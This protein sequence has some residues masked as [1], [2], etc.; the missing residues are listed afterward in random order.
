[1]VT[2]PR[3]LQEEESQFCFSRPHR[4]DV[5]FNSGPA[6]IRPV[7]GQSPFLLLLKVFVRMKQ[8]IPSKSLFWW[9]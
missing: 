2:V 4:F 3:F 9:N 8:H 5:H 6:K 1:M 7:F